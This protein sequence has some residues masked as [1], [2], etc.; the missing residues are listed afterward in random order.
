MLTIIS[1]I[2][3]LFLI[4]FVG[5]V[6]RK[7]GYLGDEWSGIL[8]EYALKLGLPVL[9]F[10][11][12]AGTPLSFSAEAGLIISNSLFILVTFLL[13]W[14]TGSLLRLDARMMRTLFMCAVFGNVAYLGIPVLSQTAG[15]GVLPT[16]SLIIGIYLFWLFSLGIGYLDYSI[17]HDRRGVLKNVLSGLYRN[18]LLLALFFGIIAGS[19][20]IR[21][22]SM[23]TTAM[24]M[25]TASVTPTV[26]IVI[27]LFIGNSRLG[28]VREWLPIL[29]FSLVTLL[30]LPALFYL[31]VMLFGFSPP[32]FSV[33]IIEA[34]MP[35]AITPF[36]LADQ[37]RLD[38]EFI[39]RSIVL[40]TVLSVVSLPFWIWMV[41]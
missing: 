27:G 4:V 10:S 14:L 19:L 12:L 25:I 5:A 23:L 8:N 22:P 18:P 33:S 15:E 9:V 11:S 28:K 2:A 1:I 40:S 24:D 16:V 29:L 3:P 34:A 36:A 21:L 6:L 31:G 7:S 32:V 17:R 37:Y 20:Q 30:V 13:A 35:L 26:L 38:K 41:R 39:A